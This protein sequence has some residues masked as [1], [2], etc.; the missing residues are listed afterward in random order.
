MLGN[1]RLIGEL[2]KKGVVPEAITH[3]CIAELVG[4][5]K[6]TK[7]PAEDNVEVSCIQS[8][9]FRGLDTTRLCRPGG[10]SGPLAYAPHPLQA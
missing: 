5:P 7:D 10:C 4:D 9:F 8:T 2:F 6:S 1:I 3:L